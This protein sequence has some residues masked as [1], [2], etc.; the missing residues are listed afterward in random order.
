MVAASPPADL[1]AGGGRRP[2][3]EYAGVEHIEDLE[4]NHLKDVFIAVIAVCMVGPDG[5]D[6]DQ[7]SISEAL[8]DKGVDVVISPKNCTINGDL[9]RAWVESFWD[10]ATD[11][12]FVLGDCA[13]NTGIEASTQYPNAA[14]A[15]RLCVEQFRFR[16]DVFSIDTWERLLPAGYGDT[17]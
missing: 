6:E 8:L 4:A 17:R 16:H 7:Y 3:W 12:E 13:I 5:T 15:Y 11:G 9:G 10:C 14:M 1:P 2:G